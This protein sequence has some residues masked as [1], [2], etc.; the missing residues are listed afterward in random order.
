LP[1]IFNHTHTT[2][3]DKLPGPKAVATI[4]RWVGDTFRDK[5]EPKKTQAV[6]K[7]LGRSPRRQRLRPLSKV[8]RKS[9]SDVLKYNLQ[10]CERK[11]L[12]VVRITRS[13]GKK[14]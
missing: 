11:Q 2:R 9:L 1:Y 14:I 5:R 3:K 7:S 6:Q 12:K 8:G 4:G 13:S 10:G